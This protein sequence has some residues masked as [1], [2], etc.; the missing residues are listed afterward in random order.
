LDAREKLS[1]DNLLAAMSKEVL[2]RV[3]GSAK[4]RT[5]LLPLRMG[6]FLMLRELISINL[7]EV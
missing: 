3:D 7:E 5:T 1:A 4:K 2:V 6:T